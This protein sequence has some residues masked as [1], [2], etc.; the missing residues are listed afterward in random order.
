[1][2]MIRELAETAVVCLALLAL[3]A[4]HGGPHHAK[5][6]PAAPLGNTHDDG[7]I[8]ETSPSTTAPSVTG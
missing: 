4:C 3:Q 5:P 7:P 8:R 1:M 6:A 2:P